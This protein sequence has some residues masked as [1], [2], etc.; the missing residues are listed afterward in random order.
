[1]VYSGLHKISCKTVVEILCTTG[2]D[3][4]TDRQTNRQT[5]RWM[6]GRKDLNTTI[7]RPLQSDG[8]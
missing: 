6:N 2:V 7:L 1:M 4:Q 3:R 5:E 8:A